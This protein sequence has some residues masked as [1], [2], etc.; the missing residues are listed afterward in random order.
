MRLPS[1]CGGDRVCLSPRHGAERE[2][3]GRGI[4]A[5]ANRA[6]RGYV[7]RDATR[8]PRWQSAWPAPRKHP[9]IEAESVTARRRTDEAEQVQ[10]GRYP[11]PFDVKLSAQERHN[12]RFRY[13]NLCLASGG[14]ESRIRT[15]R[16]LTQPPVSH[17]NSSAGRRGAGKAMC[18]AFSK[19]DP[20]QREASRRCGQTHQ[21]PLCRR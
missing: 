4:P 2:T 12:L 11:V 14:G 19:P 18:A 17:R 16:R 20:C 5:T 3:R 15:H 8:Y 21:A 9:R 1:Q 10:R 6:L 13:E 7:S